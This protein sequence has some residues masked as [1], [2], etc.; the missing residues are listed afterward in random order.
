MVHYYTQLLQ[1]GA[2]TIPLFRYHR[3]RPPH[4]STGV[5]WGNLSRKSWERGGGGGRINKRTP[6][7]SFAS[8][9]SLCPFIR[10]LPYQSPKLPPPPPPFVTKRR[11]SLLV[12]FLLLIAPRQ[13]GHDSAAVVLHVK[14]SPSI[15]RPFY[16]R[17]HT[18]RCHAEKKPGVT[19]NS[20]IRS[21]YF[22]LSNVVTPP[23][24]GL[25]IRPPYERRRR[26][27]TSPSPPQPQRAV[28]AATI[29]PS[30]LSPFV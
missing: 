5:R 11:P 30:F 21:I 6:P 14:Y 17:L 25:Q 3:L 16:V 13:L 1:G 22:C 29:R 2:R 18:R 8:I 12:Y 20:H 4:V 10:V 28:V 15:I 19:L 27:S 23:L 24:R 26:L 7:I 9:L